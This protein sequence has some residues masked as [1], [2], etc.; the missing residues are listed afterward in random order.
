MSTQVGAE[1]LAAGGGCFLA[2]T[3]PRHRPVSQ[4]SS[5][6][7]SLSSQRRGFRYTQQHF[8]VRRP[9]PSLSTTPLSH[10]TPRPASQYYWR[11]ENRTGSTPPYCHCRPGQTS[12]KQGG[13]SG[14]AFQMQ[15]SGSGCFCGRR[16]LFHRHRLRS[17]S[18]RLCLARSHSVASLLS[19]LALKAS[20]LGNGSEW[21]CRRCEDSARAIEVPP[22]PP[23]ELRQSPNRCG[24]SGIQVVGRKRMVDEIGFGETFACDAQNSIK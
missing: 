11:Q 20:S 3:W 4:S 9:R 24:G 16:V 1:G 10:R 8:D 5:D 19:L 23:S 2:S 6:S 21:E 15:D 7:S 13:T 14:G 18:A 22:I 17:P 12:A